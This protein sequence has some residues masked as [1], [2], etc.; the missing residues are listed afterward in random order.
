MNIQTPSKWLL[1]LREQNTTQRPT[2]WACCYAIRLISVAGKRRSNQ[3]F[4]GRPVLMICTA[5][6]LARKAP[7]GIAANAKI[8]ARSNSLFL[9]GLPSLMARCFRS[10]STA[11]SFLGMVKLSRTSLTRFTLTTFSD[12]GL[13][14]VLAV[15]LAPGADF[16][17]ATLAFTLVAA[18][19]KGKGATT[20][21]LAW[22]GAIAA[23]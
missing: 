7:P 5:F 23:T 6:K 4:A 8:P 12:L 10:S 16:A 3:F 15:A 17:A 2:A 21:A 11:Y 22:G 20:V 1:W 18:L 19:V 9:I 14:V 13:V